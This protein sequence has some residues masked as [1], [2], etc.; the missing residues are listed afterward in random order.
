[1]LMDIMKMELIP[2]KLEEERKCWEQFKTQERDAER[3]ELVNLLEGP[4][5]SKVGV[6]KK[7]I[8]E[9]RGAPKE[10]GVKKRRYSIMEEDW[11]EHN[12]P[13]STLCTG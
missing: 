1:M 2:N 3:R 9:K 11:G 6:R 13:C 10:R 4:S 8:N 5:K 12:N 7:R